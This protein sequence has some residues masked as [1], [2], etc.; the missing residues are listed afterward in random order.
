MTIEKASEVF[1][2]VLTDALG[3]LQKRTKADAA[4]VQRIFAPVFESITR[5]LD[6]KHEVAAAQLGAWGPA[7]VTADGLRALV[8]EIAESAMPPV[9]LEAILRKQRELEEEMA[10]VPNVERPCFA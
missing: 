1:E 8:R 5:A 3:R 2:P 7:D 4:D 10:A 6:G 9:D